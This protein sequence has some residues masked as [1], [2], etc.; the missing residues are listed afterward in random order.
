MELHEKAQTPNISKLYD[1]IFTIKEMLSE[2]VNTAMEVANDAESFGGEVARVITGQLRQNLIPAVQKYIDDKSNPS[3]ATAIISFL[4]SV[5][6]AWIRVGPEQDPNASTSGASMIDQQYN[7][8]TASMPSARPTVPNAAT[9]A[10]ANMVSQTAGTGEQ[11]ESAILHTRK[12][13]LREELRQRW[14]EEH[15]E[16]PD[17]GRLNFNSLRES[18]LH[19]PNQSRGLT[20]DQ[21][22]GA[23]TKEDRVFENIVEKA[24]RKMTQ[25][26]EGTTET[27]SKGVER[28]QEKD[29]LMGPYEKEDMTSLEEFSNWKKLVNDDSGLDEA[30]ALA[31]SGQ[32]VVLEE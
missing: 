32:E 16:T 23:L 8:T 10:E 9:A 29:F 3:A 18:F 12:D 20:P 28:M 17:D 5:P 31:K 1:K 24:E 2:V 19:E 21:L 11:R 15:A 13:A 7:A 27:A 26:P 6:L 25:M 4:D 22:V 30:L 14:E